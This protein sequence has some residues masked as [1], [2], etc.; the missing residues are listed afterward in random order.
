MFKVLNYPTF[1]ILRLGN[2]NLIKIKQGGKKGKEKKTIQRHTQKPIY[3]SLSN[4]LV[5]NT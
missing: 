3:I 1:T 5:T 2:D 4:I